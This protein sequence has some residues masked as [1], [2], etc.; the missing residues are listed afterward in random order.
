[1]HSISSFEKLNKETIPYI[2]VNELK[3]NNLVFLDAREP[4]E[5]SS[6]IQGAIPV[7]FDH[8]YQCYCKTKTRTNTTLS[9][10]P[11]GAK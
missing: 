10:A 11:L 6:H 4:K 8:L 2:K 3:E 9:I 5:Y 1:L 7:G